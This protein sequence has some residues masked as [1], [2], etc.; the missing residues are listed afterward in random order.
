MRDHL[1]DK[2]LVCEQVILID[3]DIF[4]Y[5]YMCVYTCIM[6]EITL[7]HILTHKH[8]QNLVGLYDPLFLLFQKGQTPFATEDTCR[9]SKYTLGLKFC[10]KK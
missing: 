10:W 1:A 6:W 9:T 3:V 4:A 8:T 5:I 2:T 7:V